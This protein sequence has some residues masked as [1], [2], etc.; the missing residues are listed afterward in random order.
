MLYFDSTFMLFMWA[1]L[2][3]GACNELTVDGWWY[4]LLEL[5]A[6]LAFAGATGSGAG[7]TSPS[8]GFF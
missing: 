4:E 5:L 6:L 7:A 3:G 1:E 8:P 2:M